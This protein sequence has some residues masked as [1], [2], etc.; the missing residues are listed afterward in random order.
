MDLI[1]VNNLSF[2]YGEKKVINNISFNVNDGE[3]FGIIGPNGSGKTTLLRLMTGL[4]NSSDGEIQFNGNPISNYGKK[5]LARLFAVV[6]QEGTPPLAFSVEEVVAMGRYPWLKPFANLTKLDHQIIHKAL[7][8]FELLGIRNQPVNTLSG[9]QRQLVSLARAMVQQPKVLFLDEPTTYLD[10]GNQQS[11]MRHIRKWQE[12]KGLT[13]IMVLHDLNLAA[14]YCDRLV[15]LD[16][17]SIKAIGKVEEVIREQ[18][19]EK[20]YK[21][22]PILVKH[23]LTKVPQ[24]L[25]N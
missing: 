5:E 22:K 10:I 3:S 2:K 14:Q 7:T 13:T 25:L 12:E 1:R 19:I 6:E 11:L 20:V 17:G 23:P 16:Q 21:I 8:T 4:L 9:G 24:I 15:L 18:E